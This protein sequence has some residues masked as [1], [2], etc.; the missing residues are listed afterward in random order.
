MEISLNGKKNESAAGT[1]LCLVKE[2][3][4]DPSCLIAEVNLKVVPQSE[5]AFFTLNDGDRIELLSL[6]GGG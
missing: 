2:Q 4:L 5:W 3:G 1:L 6:V